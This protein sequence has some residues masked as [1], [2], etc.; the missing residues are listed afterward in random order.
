MLLGFERQIPDKE[1]GK[2]PDN[3]WCDVNN[4]CGWFEKEYGKKYRYVIISTKTLEYAANFKYEVRII[5]KGNLRIFKNM[6][7]EFIKALSPYQLNSITE[8]KLQELVDTLD[9]TVIG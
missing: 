2:G 4:H 7:N 1:I 9:L 5:R 8:E 6:V 3:L